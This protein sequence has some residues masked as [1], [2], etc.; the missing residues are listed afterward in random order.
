MS[1]LN[2]SIINYKAHH[3]ACMQWLIEFSVP[4]IYCVQQ[5]IGP[6]SIGYR[7]QEIVVADHN[8]KT[9]S[10]SGDYSSKSDQEVS[11]C[12]DF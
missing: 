12:G 6:I 5:C 9:Q 8:H 11:S 3:C 7:V 10:P 4:I 2:P 1:I